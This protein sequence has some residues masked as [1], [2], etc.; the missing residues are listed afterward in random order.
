MELKPDSKLKTIDEMN[1][2]ISSINNQIYKLD[3]IHNPRNFEKHHK[4][5]C[6]LVSRREKLCYQI[7][8]LEK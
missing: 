1:E 4:K 8:E 3:G 5:Y 2:R 7:R 6:S